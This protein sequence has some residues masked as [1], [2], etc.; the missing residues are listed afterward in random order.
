[1]QIVAIQ[2]NSYESKQGEK[3]NI[4]N[5]SHTISDITK[6]MTKFD[7][8]NSTQVTKITD[9]MINKTEENITKFEKQN[10]EWISKVTDAMISKTEEIFSKFEEKNNKM[11]NIF[12]NIA[13]LIEP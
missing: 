11:E 3:L 1:M 13:N 7:Q 2:D 6:I 9:A 12:S 8:M 10:D 5:S 4:E